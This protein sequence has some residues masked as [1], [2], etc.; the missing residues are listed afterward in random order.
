MKQ[1]KLSPALP[2]GPNNLVSLRAILTESCGWPHSFIAI[3]HGN[4]TDQLIQQRT[5]LIPPLPTTCYNLH[6]TA[7]SGS[8]GRSEAGAEAESRSTQ[9]QGNNSPSG[10]EFQLIMEPADTW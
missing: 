2:S 5:G 6:F 8:D 10:S 4:G 1:K 7:S 3:P 9:G